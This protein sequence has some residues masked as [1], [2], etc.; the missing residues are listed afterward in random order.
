MEKEKLEKGNEIQARISDLDS[1]IKILTKTQG[2]RAGD[3]IPEVVAVIVDYKYLYNSSET[4]SI[5]D[6]PELQ[7]SIKDLVSKY[8]QDR[9]DDAEKEFAAL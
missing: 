8:L 4:I 5:G 7:Q 9:K 6:Y 3:T 2:S 1:K